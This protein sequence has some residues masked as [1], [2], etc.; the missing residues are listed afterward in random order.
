MGGGHRPGTTIVELSADTPEA[1]QCREAGMGPCAGG[2]V[3]PDLWGS[4]QAAEGGN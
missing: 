1:D 3:C 2:K 4:L